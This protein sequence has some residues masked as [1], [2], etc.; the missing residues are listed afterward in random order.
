MDVGSFMDVT[1][2]TSAQLRYEGDTNIFVEVFSEGRKVGSFE[3]ING[4][5]WE[6]D[7]YG[8]VAFAVPELSSWL[9]R[10]SD[11]PIFDLYDSDTETLEFDIDLT[12]GT[13]SGF[14]V[15][16]RLDTTVPFT[17]HGSWRQL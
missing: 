3:N 2:A 7:V 14:R 13:G 8:H 1:K 12:T 11:L 4:E 6:D 9:D 15:T 17:Q 16:R 5:G 10:F